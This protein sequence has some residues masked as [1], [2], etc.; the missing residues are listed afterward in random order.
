MLRLSE[1][2]HAEG[3]V[4]DALGRELSACFQPAQLVEL[5][6]LAGLYHAVSY[7]VNACGVP[8]E[9]WGARAPAA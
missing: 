2:L 9:E 8:L 6:V 5:V 7:V 3:R 1:A 4:D